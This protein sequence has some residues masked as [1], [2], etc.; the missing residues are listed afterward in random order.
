VRKYIFFLSLHERP[1]APENT[2][3]IGESRMQEELPFKK[4]DKVVTVDDVPLGE[5]AGCR[6][7]QAVNFL[8]FKLWKIMLW[9]LT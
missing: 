5:A 2:I 8:P 1:Y 4:Y 3:K 6:R 9:D 7:G